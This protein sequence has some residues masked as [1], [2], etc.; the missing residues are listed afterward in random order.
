MSKL[1]E[2]STLDSLDNSPFPG[3]VWIPGGTFTMGS[4]NH[5]PEE[6]PTHRVTV[7]G[8]W[9]DEKLATNAQ[10]R[11]FVKETGFRTQAEIAPDAAHYPGAKP[12]L[13]VPGSIV[14]RKPRQR[15]DLNN[16]YNWWAWVPGANWRHPY[17]PGTRNYG[18][19]LARGLSD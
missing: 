12:E 16:H 14:F 18:Q 8:F 5:Y 2:I 13:L 9:M 4:N 3:M 17:G 7:D 15:V 11:T 1:S 6:A 19:H 10:F